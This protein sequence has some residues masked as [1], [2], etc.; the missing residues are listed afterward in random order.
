MNK[1][2]EAI[3]RYNNAM[4]LVN[5]AQ[6]NM[7]TC[8][9]SHLSLHEEYKN[10]LANNSA[11]RSEIS[12]IIEQSNTE[13]KLRQ[14]NEDFAVVLGK[15]EVECTHLLKAI[16]SVASDFKIDVSTMKAEV[17]CFLATK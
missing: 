6:T 8:E 16:T 12:E 11:L 15:T 7:N 9:H 4:L 10:Y 3:L 13:E 14:E 2:K 17:E 1:F 5:K